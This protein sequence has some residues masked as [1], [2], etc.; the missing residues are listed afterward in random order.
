MYD[1]NQ[2][3]KGK[4]CLIDTEYDNIDS[5]KAT[6]MWCAS[7]L[8]LQTKES[9][10]FH[11]KGEGEDQYHDQFAEKL[12]EYL[13]GFDYFVA[14]NLWGAEYFVLKNLIGFEIQPYQAIDTLVLSRMQRPLAPYADKFPELKS[15]GL[16]TR[17]GGHSLAAWGKRL[18]VPKIN[19]DKFDHFSWEML[20]Y[21][22][23]DRDLNLGVYEYLLWEQEECGF[24]PRSLYIENE[25]H[26][27]L[28]R[29]SIDGF[30]LHQGRAKKLDDRDWE[31][32]NT[33]TY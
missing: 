5:E 18:G 19:F 3:I 6:K 24:D 14:H 7:C 29:Q 30:T 8:D 2:I 23:R 33:L 4:G 13:K 32:V 27:R 12:K 21:C 26:R 17:L 10:N 16:D 28:V 22:D 25:A 1:I 31:T 11:P 15:K 9:R 20:K